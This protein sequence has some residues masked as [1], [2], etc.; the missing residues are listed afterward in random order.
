MW[1]YL[2]FTW[3]CSSYVQ[4][5]WTAGGAAVVWNAAKRVYCIIIGPNEYAFM[6]I[7]GLTHGDLAKQV[8]D[9]VNKLAAMAAAG[10]VVKKG[11]FQCFFFSRNIG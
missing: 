3:L 8:I 7:L 11:A 2:S 1:I 9:F 5:A 4:V 10:S 6:P